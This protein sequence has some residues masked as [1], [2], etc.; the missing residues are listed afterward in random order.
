MKKVIMEII[1]AINQAVSTGE[2]NNG[3]QSIFSAFNCCN[4]NYYP[5]GGGVGFHADDEYLVDGLQQPARIVSLSLTSSSGKKSGS[6][7]RILQLRKKQD[8]EGGNITNEK[9][10]HYVIEVM[11]KHGDMFAME[12][13]FQRHYLHSVWPGESI[14]ST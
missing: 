6:G 12:G 9:Y 5:R 13:Y 1:E 8:D 14:R 7:A 4:F 11:L 3:G 10:N 2:D